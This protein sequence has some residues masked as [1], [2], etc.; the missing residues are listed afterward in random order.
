[1]SLT[2]RLSEL[3]RACFT[4]IWIVS[5]EHP[6]ALTEIAR[7]CQAESWRLATWDLEVGLTLNGRTAEQA[8]A[9]PLA[10]IRA[11]G[12]LGSPDS[13]S[14][15][16]L[17]NFHRFLQ[18]PEIVQA[19]IHQVNAGK[20]N[21]TFVIILSPLVQVPTELEKQFVVVEHPL[22]DRAQLDE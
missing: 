16:V 12:A 17:V 8:A 22:P 5:H 18:S 19:L 20:Q 21:R 15:L 9:D 4:G 13:S 10:A 11:L 14:L 3:V 1:M 7:L 6:D 2:A